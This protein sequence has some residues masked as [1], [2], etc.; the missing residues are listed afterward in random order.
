MSFGVASEL[1]V[2]SKC[3][4]EFIPQL[5]LTE[6][7]WVNHFKDNRRIFGYLIFGQSWKS[8]RK[9]TK[10]IWEDLAF[11]GKVLEY[12]GTAGMLEL[13]WYYRKAMLAPGVS[14]D[15]IA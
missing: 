3:L 9:E 2:I 12:W 7:V 5:N 15:K 1:T 11:H 10:L 14:I 4:K 13:K 6:A 8:G